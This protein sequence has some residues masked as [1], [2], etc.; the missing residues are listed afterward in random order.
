[1]LSPKQLAFIK[2]SSRF[3][4]AR[5]SRRSGKTFAGAAYMILT[6]LSSPST[7]VLYIGLTRE[8][9]KEAVW[10]TLI[11]ILDEL[12]IPHE[13]RPS[14]LRIKFPNGSFIR[15]FGADTTNAKDRLRGQKFKLVIID[16]VGFYSSMDTIIPVVIPMLADYAGTLAMTS[17]PGVLLSGYFYESDVGDNRSSWSQHNWNMGDNKYF[18]VP[19]ND[20]SKYVNRAEEE[21]DTICKTMYGGNRLHPAFVREYLGQWVRDNTALVYPFTDLNLIDKPYDI[22]KPQYGIGVD[23]G[24][25]SASAISVVKYSEYTREVQI[26]ETWSEAEVMIDDFA[27]ILKDYMA[28]Y[29]TDLVVADTGGLGAAV[30]QELRKRYML[31]IRAATKTDKSFHQRIFANDL[32]SG[33]IKCVAKLNVVKEWAKI[34]KDESGEEIKGQ[35]NHEADATLYIYRYIY[36]TYLKDQVPVQTDE[37]IMIEQLTATALKEKFEQEEKQNDAY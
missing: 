13:A 33:F 28:K 18:Q 3:K 11:T 23:I 29:N 10:G 9:A 4:L 32:L 14:A 16:E 34:I 37:E 22:L 35:K 20:P 12:N 30:V 24:V 5:A 2:D 7:P 21:L 31:P 25:S 17:S 26:V 6:A 19:A 1:M 36:T 15:L 8:T 27:D